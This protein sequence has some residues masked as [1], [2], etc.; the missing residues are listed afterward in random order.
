MDEPNDAYLRDLDGDGIAELIWTGEVS[1][2]W[3]GDYWAFYPQRLA[4]HVFRWDG[5]NYTAQLVEY[6]APQF[7]FQAVQDGDMYSKAGF[8]EKALE[9]YQLA[10]TSDR[11]KWWT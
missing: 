1:P 11:L 4:T 7:R 3:H 6:S 9:S 5:V 10:I 2:E 8:Y